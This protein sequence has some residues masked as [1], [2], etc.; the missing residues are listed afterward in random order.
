[1]SLV[2]GTGVSAAGW[3][4]DGVGAR[5]G[6]FSSGS[7]PSGFGEEGPPVDGGAAAS[8][9]SGRSCG[10]ISPAGVVFPDPFSLVDGRGGGWGIPAS[11]GEL[12]GA[13]WPAVGGA[14]AGGAAAGA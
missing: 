5:A 3:G 14:S 6:A 2:S 4:V 10:F 12:C 1:G 8:P 11:D 9:G 13:G 7:P